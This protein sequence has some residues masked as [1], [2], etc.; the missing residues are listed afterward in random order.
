ML[1]EF[2]GVSYRTEGEKD[3]GYTSVSD[4]SELIETYARML[5][6][7]RESKILFGYCYTQLT[8][9]EQEVNGLFTYHREPKVSPE[10]IKAINDSITPLSIQNLV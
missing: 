4:E 9:V 2:G 1:T 3:W 5:Q 7:I 8:D 6:A 10:A